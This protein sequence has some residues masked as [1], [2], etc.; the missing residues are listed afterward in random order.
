VLA[1]CSHGV[2]EA[3]AVLTLAPFR[4][5][6][7][8]ALAYAVVVHVVNV[9]PVILVGY[10]ALHRHVRAARRPSTTALTEGSLGSVGNPEAA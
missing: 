2:F 10:V 8:Q 9:L 4:V 1:G 3:A 6:R 7:S 5:D